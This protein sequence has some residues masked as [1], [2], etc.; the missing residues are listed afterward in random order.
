MC[1]QC[2]VYVQV[3]SSLLHTYD[4]LH[5][6]SSS[7]L[8]LLLEPFCLKFSEVLWK[9]LEVLLGDRGGWVN[10]KS[11]SPCYYSTLLYVPLNTKLELFSVVPGC[12][13]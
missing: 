11:L 6:A 10:N 1:V 3:R 2:V 12:R 8:K 7:V 13:A 4:F 5:V 9:K